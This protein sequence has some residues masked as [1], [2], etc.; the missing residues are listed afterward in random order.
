M[1]DVS[2][3]VLVAGAGVYVT[4]RGTPGYGTVLPALLEGRRRGLVGE[5][6]LSATRQASLDEA[7]ERTETLGHLMG[8]DGTVRCVLSPVS[9]KADGENHTPNWLRSYRFLIPCMRMWLF[10]F[11]RAGSLVLS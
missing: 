8:V 2:V 11:S 5:I 7:L 1:V 4:G 3:D 6:I 9:P 10:L